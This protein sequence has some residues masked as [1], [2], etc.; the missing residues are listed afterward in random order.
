MKIL[1]F[2]LSFPFYLLAAT[3]WV[4][5]ALYFISFADPTLRTPTDSTLIDIAMALVGHVGV[6]V[7]N[8]IEAK[9]RKASLG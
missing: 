7:I 6:A 3:G 4:G 8:A 5:I 1:F 2:I 9:I